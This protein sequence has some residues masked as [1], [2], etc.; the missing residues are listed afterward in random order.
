MLRWRHVQNISVISGHKLPHVLKHS[1]HIWSA[2]FS[3]ES[4]S[5]I[6][7]VRLSVCLSVIKTPQSLRIAPIYHWVYRPLSLSTIEPINHQAYLKSSLLTI[8][9]IDYWAYQPLSLM[10]LVL[11]SR[12]LSLSACFFEGFPKLRS[13][14]TFWLAVVFW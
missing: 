5:T 2:I 8:K 12:L 14:N 3:R 6:A 13:S 10:T 11:L 7:N 1:S 4:N 9:P